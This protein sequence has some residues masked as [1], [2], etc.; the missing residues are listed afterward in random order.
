MVCSILVICHVHPEIE[1]VGLWESL[2][3]MVTPSSSV[4]RVGLQPATGLK[5]VLAGSSRGAA[6]TAAGSALLGDVQLVDL[7]DFTLEQAGD[8]G[9]VTD[10]LFSQFQRFRPA[11]YGAA[12][13]CPAPGFSPSILH[14]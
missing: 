10:L 4:G 7:R 6:V 14:D 13:L 12:H 1:S 5:T 9:R 8:Y 2:G 3:E 11:F